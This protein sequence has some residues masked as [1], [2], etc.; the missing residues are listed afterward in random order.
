MKKIFIVIFNILLCI[1]VCG[2]A[3]TNDENVQEKAKKVE[4]ILSGGNDYFAYANDNVP[5][6]SAEDKERLS[7]HGYEYYSAL[8]DLGRCGYAEACVGPETMPSEKR[9]SIGQVKPSGWHLAKYDFIDGKYLYNRCHLIAFQL[10]G[11]NANDHNLITGT[12]SLNINGMLPYENKVAE[13]IKKTG[14]H[15]MYRSTPVF[16]EEN[17]LASYVKIEAESIEDNEIK[18]NVICF[19]N[20]DGVEIDYK[21]G[22][23]KEK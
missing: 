20:Q 15:I 10:T 12:R 21:T 8:D 6:F 13:Y 2:C 3:Y 16:E 9:G 1:S 4:N 14:N 5:E 17:L 23:S 19:N 22:D 18:F 11:E 7:I